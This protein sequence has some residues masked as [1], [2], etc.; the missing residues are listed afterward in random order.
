MTGSSETVGKGW[1]QNPLANAGNGIVHIGVGAF[2]RAHQAVYTQQAM[3]AAGGD[4]RIIG[5]T[6]RSTDIAD[7]LNAQDG[8]FCVIVRNPAG[9]ECQTIYTISHVLA[10]ARELDAVL[11]ALS[12][13]AIRIVTLTVTEKAYGIDR[14]AMKVLSDHPAIAHDLAHPGQPTGVIGILTEALRRR[15]DAGNAPFTCLCCDNLPENGAVLRAGMVDFASRL[16]ADLGEWIAQ[17]VHFPSSMVDRITPAST[18]ATYE[19]VRAMTGHNDACAVETEPFSQW[20][21]EDDFPTGRPAW[22]KAGVLMVDDVRPYEHMKLRMLNGTH[23]LIAYLG[24]LAGYKYVRDV[25]ADEDCA[26]LVHAHM[27]AAAQ[28]LVPVAALDFASYADDLVARFQNPAIAHETRQIAMDGTEKLPQRLLHPAQDALKEGKEIATYAIAV[29]FWM[30]YLHKLVVQRNGNDISDPRQAEIIAALSGKAAAQDIY[31]ALS[32]LPG[33]FPQSLLSSSV[34][35]QA[36]VS[37]L[38]CILTQGA[39]GAVTAELG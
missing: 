18:D 25:M 4:W 17:N 27:L 13:P 12:D 26:K 8:A 20:V 5:V 2:H 19:T 6:P 38:D 29:A 37:R 16:D 23:S 32:Q 10:A 30:A 21:I 28:T 31:N 39:L 7:Q 3:L 24:Q 14:Q 1:P 35:M 34:W 36:V 9:D 11:D 22:E 15:R 33:L